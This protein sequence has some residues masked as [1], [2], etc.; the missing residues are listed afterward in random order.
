M[1]AEQRM[2]KHNAAE[3][4]KEQEWEKSPRPPLRTLPLSFTSPILSF[5]LP[6]HSLLRALRRR[7]RSDCLREP[8]RVRRLRDDARA[9]HGEHPLDR[10]GREHVE[11]DGRRAVDVHV[12]L[13]AG[14]VVDAVLGVVLFWLCAGAR[15]ILARASVRM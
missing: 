13:L 2:T 12:L 10:D 7:P 3:K 6:F 9:V 11:R 5:P 8:I 15:G 14:V 1:N 4:E